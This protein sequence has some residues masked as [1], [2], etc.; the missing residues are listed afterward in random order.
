MRTAW[1]ILRAL[2]RAGAGHNFALE[3]LAH[4]PT[5]FFPSGSQIILISPL[6]P[7]DPPLV[8]HLVSLGY[9]V[10][11]IS[12]D[13]LLFE[14]PEIANAA[15]SDEG[16]NLAWRLARSERRFILKRLE[17]RG[18]RVIDWDVRQPLAPLLQRIL[19]R[20]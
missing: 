5:R 13:P 16:Q 18:V 9:G 14:S 8:A 11:V 12:P 6:L 1:N 2:S 17:R 7:E 10:L 19:K 3:S 4:L 20:G 15:D